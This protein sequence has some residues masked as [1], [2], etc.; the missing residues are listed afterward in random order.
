MWC[1]AADPSL[2]GIG[3]LPSAFSVALGAAAGRLGPVQHL[4][5]CAGALSLPCPRRGTQLWV[6]DK[7]F[8]FVGF[9]AVWM[10]GQASWGHEWGRKQVVKV[11]DSSQVSRRSSKRPEDLYRLG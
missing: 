5:N 1:L 11:M 9:N 7:P 8:Y 3:S 10:I 2:P 6:D 4:S